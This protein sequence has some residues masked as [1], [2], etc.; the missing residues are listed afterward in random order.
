MAV[1]NPRL[2]IARAAQQQAKSSSVQ[3][4]QSV[5]KQQTMDS[6]LNR[7]YTAMGGANTVPDAG[8]WKGLVT[9]ILQSPVGKVVSKAGE[10]ISLPGRAVTSTVM[11]LKDA[12]DSDPNTVASWN[13]FTK[14]QY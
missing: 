13:D 5:L 14:Q 4:L 9:D 2:D 8:G 6:T 12:L 10:I 11:E 3:T 7:D 1:Y